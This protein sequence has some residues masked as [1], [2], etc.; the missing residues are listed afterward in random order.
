MTPQARREATGLSQA[1]MAV[2]L[3]VTQ[4]AV[5]AYEAGRRSPARAAASKYAL[6]EAA[7]HGPVRCYGAFRGR[8]IELPDALWVPA[9]PSAGTWRLPVH[10][11]W[12]TRRPRDLADIEERRV[13]YAKVLTEGKPSDI[14]LWVDPRELAR[15]WPD[16]AVPRHLVSPV[17]EMLH[18]LGLTK[19]EVV[20][21]NVE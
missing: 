19:G 9:I 12:S 1:A 5:A 8:P 14:R 15:L 21:V 17:G 7:L 20:A 4:P 16:V 18:R 11:E 13:A 3:G 6:I 2:V 10:V